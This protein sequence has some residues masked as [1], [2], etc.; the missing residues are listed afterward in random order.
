VDLA[1]MF[2]KLN[3]MELWKPVL[4]PMLLG[5]IPPGIVTAVALYALTFYTVRGFQTRRRTRLMER[6]RLRLADPASDIPSV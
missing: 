4:E 2:H 5:A 6:A 3:F 1:A